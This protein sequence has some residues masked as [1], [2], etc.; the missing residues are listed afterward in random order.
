[1]TIG[2]TRDLCRSQ[3]ACTI[4][5]LRNLREEGLTPMAEKFSELWDRMSQ[6]AREAASRRAAELKTGMRVEDGVADGHVRQHA[7]QLHRGD[8]RATGDHRPV[9]HEQFASI[10]SAGEPILC[11]D[12][13]GK[14]SPNGEDAIK[15]GWEPV[16]V[17]PLKPRGG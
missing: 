10:T 1:M 6:A 8:G 15:F 2:G 11:G 14:A 4:H 3:I 9:P 17:V 7:S 5:T 16:S 13:I 12:D